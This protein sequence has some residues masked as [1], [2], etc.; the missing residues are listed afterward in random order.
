M[1]ATAPLAAPG[2]EAELLLCCARV[3]PGPE[4][5]RRAGAI[6]AGPLDWARLVRLALHHKVTP[7]LY[8]ALARRP[9]VPPEIRAALRRHQ[10]E[11]ARHGLALLAELQALL[12]GFER[13]GI[14][15]VPFKGPALAELAYGSLS[16]RLAGD[17]D[18][19]V[20]PVDVERVAAQLEARGYVEQTHHRTGRPLDAT[21]D[22]WY[23]HVQ[24]EYVY[25]RPRDGMVVE[26]HWTL[27]PRPLAVDL[28]MAGIWRRTRCF[29][30]A[31]REVLG[32]ALEDLVLALCV[33]GS[34]HEWTELRWIGDVAELTA[35]HPGIDWPAALAHADERG[36]ARMLRLGLALAER[37]L[38][39]PLPAAA[40]ADV[41]ADA[42]VPGLAAHVEQRLFDPEYNAPSVFRV[43]RFRLRMRER[44]RDRVA[45]L[46]R[47]LA[48]PQIAH[49]RLLR[50]PAALRPLYGV[51]TPAIDYLA[52]PLHRR[53]APRLARGARAALRGESLAAAAAAAPRLALALEAIAAEALAE[54]ESA[55]ALELAAGARLLAFGGPPADAA[56]LRAVVVGEG[57][58]RVGGAAAVRSAGAALPFA[59]ASFDATLCRVGWLLW[60]DPEAALREVHRAARPGARVVVVA[61]APLAS[62]PLLAAADRVAHELLGGSAVR[63]AALVEP[64]ARRGAT[65]RLLRRAGFGQVAE[66][67]VWGAFEPAGARPLAHALL[68]AT[69]GLDPGELPAP[70]R[71]EMGWALGARLPQGVVRVGLRVAV[72]IRRGSEPPR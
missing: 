32:L 44:A 12:D 15:A 21:E 53:L 36:C 41:L 47:T 65:V 64:F 66:R 42:A 67:T 51:M 50:L 60:E 70:T 8:R 19:L 18:V 6:L 24:A 16:A 14:P 27:A 58:G 33:H 59:A 48:T 69:A 1:A 30:L 22:A 55:L 54:G 3:R 71:A 23:R 4:A 7:L 17:L 57:I 26:P 9:E 37:L 5:R 38:G 31:G 45:C 25:L 29:P 52:L 28:D 39:E 61:F 10:A 68:M 2:P 63:L 43:S 56:H 34:K 13:A 20:R 46:A 11:H 35:R 72:G 49:V 62:N 40:R